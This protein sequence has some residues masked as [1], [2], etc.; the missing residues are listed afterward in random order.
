MNDPIMDEI[1]N[2]VPGVNTE[3]LEKQAL[4]LQQM[5]QSSEML[6][7]S[8]QGQ[9]QTDQSQPQT[10]STEPEEIQPDEEDTRTG[11]QKFLGYDKALTNKTNRGERVTFADTFGKQG[12][13]RNP[14]NWADV[15][16][17]A[18][19]GMVDFAIDTVNLI[20]KVDIP[21]LP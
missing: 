20:P 8:D 10:G 19:A 15:P 14:L 16:A 21:I 5:Q 4:Q 1:E 2:V 6:Q 3:E 13:L 9:V 7:G 18:G 17:A 11:L 12:D